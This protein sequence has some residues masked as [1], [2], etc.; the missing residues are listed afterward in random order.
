M[1]FKMKL[2]RRCDRT[3][4]GSLSRIYHLLHV[5]AHTSANQAPLN[6][7]PCQPLLHPVSTKS[8]QSRV[9]VTIATLTRITWG[10]ELH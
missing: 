6:T 8:V 5:T 1:H 9:S 3:S 4:L 10:K 2:G 7:E